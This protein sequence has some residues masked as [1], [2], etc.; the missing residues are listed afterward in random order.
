MPVFLSMPMKC[1][2]QDKQN[3]SLKNQQQENDGESYTFVKPP[4]GRLVGWLIGLAGWL[5]W[6]EVKYIWWRL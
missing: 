1:R 2:H 3:K 5:V 6:C 4:E